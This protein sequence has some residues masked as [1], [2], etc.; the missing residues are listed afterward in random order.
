MPSPLVIHGAVRSDVG[1]VRRENEDA[2]G[3][4]PE[5]GLYVV[6]DGLGGHAAG[7]VASTLTVEAVRRSLLDTASEDLTPVLDDEGHPSLGGRRLMIALFDANRRVVDASRSD[8]RMQGMGSTVAAVLF[9]LEYDRVAIAHVGDSRIYRIRDG[10]I[11]Q[12]TE[13]HS[14]VQRLLRE[15][16]I[17]PDEARASKHRHVLVQALGNDNVA[18][19]LRIEKPETG[20]VFVICSDGIHDPI[21]PDDILRLVR[22]AGDDV[23]SICARLIALANERGGRDNSTA[24]VLQCTRRDEGTGTP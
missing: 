9:D 24:L 18:P 21:P 14:L 4:F 12:L 8:P 7:R 11:E 20:D 1:R 17:A 23:E 5:L 2:F 16:K 15:G 13:D 3:L 19:D 22:E 10:R 6:A